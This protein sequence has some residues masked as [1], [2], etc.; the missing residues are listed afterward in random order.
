MEKLN[1]LINRVVNQFRPENQVRQV[2]GRWCS[3]R[4][5]RPTVYK[6]S[7][8]DMVGNYVGSRFITPRFKFDE[9]V[10]NAVH[11]LLLSHATY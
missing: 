2:R 9:A 6:V 8:I 10:D 1:Y 3:V 11:S 5:I 4:K 7:V